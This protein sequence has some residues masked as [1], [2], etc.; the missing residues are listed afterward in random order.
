MLVVGELIADEQSDDNAARESDRKTNDVD[1]AEQWIT[2]DVAPGN[3]QVITEHDAPRLPV[4]C[5]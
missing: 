1:G 5:R 3:F 2:R 4:G